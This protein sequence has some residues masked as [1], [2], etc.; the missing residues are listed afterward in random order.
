M[1]PHNVEQV[2]STDITPKCQLNR[3]RGTSG[4]GAPHDVITNDE[5][6]Q[7]NV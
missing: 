2:S 4:Q 5:I 1:L 7:K 3:R 6:C